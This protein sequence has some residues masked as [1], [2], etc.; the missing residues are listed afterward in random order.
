L[1]IVVAVVAV[2]LLASRFVVRRE[3]PTQV[4]HVVPSQV[5]RLDF[6]RSDAPWLVLAFTSATC[7]TCADIE[8]KVVVL[9]SAQVAV[10]IV[11]YGAERALHAKYSIDAV[12]S[13]LFIDHDGVVQSSFV[14]PVSATDLWAGLARV[15]DGIAGGDCHQHD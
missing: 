9:E 14:G 6:Q 15:R 8:R 3:G 7:N 12:P 1:V 10:Q 13:V 4:G 11:E 5:D 2:A